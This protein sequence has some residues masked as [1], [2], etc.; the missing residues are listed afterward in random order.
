MGE[1]GKHALKI[2]ELLQ[3]RKIERGAIS[4]EGKYKPLNERWFGLGARR[5]L[6]QELV[7]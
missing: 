7:Q 4:M 6:G 2:M 3:L 5:I 1:I